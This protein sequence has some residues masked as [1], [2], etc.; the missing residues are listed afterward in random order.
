MP[1]KGPGI[2]L[3]RGVQIRTNRATGIRVCMYKDEP[4]V[5]RS[6]TGGLVGDDLAFGAGFDVAGLTKERDRRARIKTITGEI[7]EE[8]AVIERNMIREAG[9]VGLQKVGSGKSATYNVID[10]ETNKALNSVPLTLAMANKVMGPPPAKEEKPVNGDLQRDP[11][12][13]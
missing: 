12:E 10:L 5:F 8:F 3:N 9:G 4:G 13:G 1:N 2:D 6:S 11:D 7:N